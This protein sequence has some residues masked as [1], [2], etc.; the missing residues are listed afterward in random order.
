MKI[1]SSRIYSP[2]R[3]ILSFFFW[4]DNNLFRTCDFTALE[5][6]GWKVSV[7]NL[8]STAELEMLMGNNFAIFTFIFHLFGTIK[9]NFFLYMPHNIL[10]LICQLMTYI[11]SYSIVIT[12]S[13]YNIFLIMVRLVAFNMWLVFH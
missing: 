12:L 2:V 10:L 5:L 11:S 6:K 1:D 13:T 8:K 4:S 7:H 9:I 3:N